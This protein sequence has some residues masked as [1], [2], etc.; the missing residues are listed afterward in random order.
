MSKKLMPSSSARLKNGRLCS[1]SSVQGCAPALRHAV[2]HAAE[3]EPGHLEARLSEVDVLHEFPTLKTVGGRRPGHLRFYAIAHA[4]YAILPSHRG[5]YSFTVARIV[6]LPVGRDL[7][8][9]RPQRNPRAGRPPPRGDR[10]RRRPRRP[11]CAHGARTWRR[12]CSATSRRT[13]GRRS[14]ARG[15]MAGTVNRLR[16]GAC[17]PVGRPRE[18]LPPLGHGNY[19]VPPSPFE[20]HPTQTCRARRHHRSPTADGTLPCH[21]PCGTHPC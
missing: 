4:V 1:S 14:T 11:R 8:H 10:G 2:A 20:Q 17:R 13:T 19:N 6:P 12:A 21:T 5:P 7:P 15:R 18:A 16:V 3:A 9:A